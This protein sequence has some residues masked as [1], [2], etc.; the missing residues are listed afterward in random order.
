MNQKSLPIRYQLLLKSE[1][2]LIYQIY[3][4]LNQK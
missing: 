1:I 3:I 2:L 4:K